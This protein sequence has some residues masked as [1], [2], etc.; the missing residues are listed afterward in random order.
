[1][2][3]AREIASE[4]CADGIE[5]G[6]YL[7]HPFKQSRPQMQSW[8]AASRALAG[9][10]VGAALSAGMPAFANARASLA[11]AEQAEGELKEMALHVKE[12]ADALRDQADLL[13]EMTEAIRKRAELLE[14]EGGPEFKALIQEARGNADAAKGDAEWAV[15]Q[16]DSRQ[17]DRKPDE[18]WQQP[19]VAALYDADVS[20]ML[21]EI[22]KALSEERL[23]SALEELALLRRQALEQ[24]GLVPML[25]PAEPR[26]GQPLFVSCTAGANPILRFSSG[27]ISF[28][29]ADA[30]EFSAGDPIVVP[31][32]PGYLRVRCE[33]P[34]GHL[35]EVAVTVRPGPAA[36]TFATEASTGLEELTV[37]AGETFDVS[38]D[39]LDAAG[40]LV[41]YDE[42]RGRLSTT[43]QP[44][45]CQIVEN[46]MSIDRVGSWR[47]YCGDGE[48]L[49]HPLQVNVIPAFS[50][51]ISARVVTRQAEQP[52]WFWASALA[53]DRYGN[54][55]DSV[56]PDLRL[57]FEDVSG[58]P[59]GV[60]G[61]VAFADVVGIQT[62]FDPT[63][64]RLFY[65]GDTHVQTIMRADLPWEGGS[66]GGV[67]PPPN[68]PD[69]PAWGIKEF[70]FTPSVRDVER[71]QYYPPIGGQ[72]PDHHRPRPVCAAPAFG[73]ALRVTFAGDDATELVPVSIAYPRGMEVVNPR[74][75]M[76]FDNDHGST[77]IRRVS[78]VPGE[79]E[80]TAELEGPFWNIH[81]QVRPAYGLNRLIANVT[82]TYRGQEYVD[83][84]LC[85][86]SASPATVA[87]HDS[88]D[89]ALRDVMAVRLNGRL[90]FEGDDPRRPDRFDSSV[91]TMLAAR[92]GADETTEDMT[93]QILY[94]AQSE[95]RSVALNR[96]VSRDRPW[97]APAVEV[98]TAPSAHFAELVADRDLSLDD[99]INEEGLEDG[100]LM[101][102]ERLVPEVAAMLRTDPARMDEV[103]RA[104]NIR[105]DMTS[106]KSH[107]RRGTLDR[108]TT[109]NRPS[110]KTALL[111]AP[112]ELTQSSDLFRPHSFV[113]I[114]SASVGSVKGVWGDGDGFLVSL[115]RALDW[116]IGWGVF[117][118]PLL[119]G[120]DYADFVDSFLTEGGLETYER[121][122][123]K[124]QLQATAIKTARLIALKLNDKL[125]TPPTVP[126]CLI[127]DT[128]TRV[129]RRCSESEARSSSPR[130][131]VLA[132]EAADLAPQLVTTEVSF[133]TSSPH[134]DLE[135]VT[136]VLGE[137]RYDRV[138]GL[139]TVFV[140]RSGGEVSGGDVPAQMGISVGTTLVNVV[141]DRATDADLF[142][143]IPI[144]VSLGALL[145][146]VIG[147]R[148]LPTEVVDAVSRCLGTPAPIRLS[149]AQVDTIVRS[150][151]APTVA[152]AAAP[153]LDSL[154]DDFGAP[155]ARLVF[156]GIVVD[157]GF[158]EDM[159]TIL[160][161][162]AGTMLDAV[163]LKVTATASVNVSVGLEDGLGGG[164]ALRY[165]L[166]NG[167]VDDV[168]VGVEGMVS[169]F[170]LASVANGVGDAIEAEFAEPALDLGE[171]LGA[172][173]LPS[174]GFS[175]VAGN[176]AYP[177][178]RRSAVDELAA[179]GWHRWWHQQS[180]TLAGYRDNRI[181]LRAD[182]TMRDS[183]VC[184]CLPLGWR[185]GVAGQTEAVDCPNRLGLPVDADGDALAD[186]M[187]NASEPYECDAFLS[188]DNLG[189]HPV[190]DGE[191]ARQFDIC[192]CGGDRGVA[193][194][195]PVCSP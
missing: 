118:S 158:N 170:G 164:S 33:L 45:E 30:V 169:L 101:A 143:G 53:A 147:D 14:Q 46:R 65:T 181:E 106:M 85:P 24:R 76:K 62:A 114:G 57:T 194:T 188:C 42:A 72:F 120:T 12:L 110:I 95:L 193:A 78:G 126:V 166:I 47:V 184:R 115:A 112:D 37:E 69:F 165:R 89:P 64:P 140:A 56:S 128:D 123:I 1:M 67:C 131:T 40:W 111:V 26:V 186:F 15:L 16:I 99:L 5:H 94:E 6:S 25:W 88:T 157:P 48:L 117:Y 122:L 151:T 161:A 84:V 149:A 105:H 127:R 160:R 81:A 17:L 34:D 121:R 10:V 144:E 152:F 83:Q 138:H 55:V 177:E 80:F 190:V 137:S 167:S 23:R 130:R 9:F 155:E 28:A 102:L 104:L 113:G 4:Y 150:C 124:V 187:I 71:P 141:L 156:P 8:R 66:E 63:I 107:V 39:A 192:G 133:S 148:D 145:A 31:Q 175:V 183:P 185:Y 109:A 172:L 87:S 38:C 19:D 171:T 51:G 61:P 77:L 135:V 43:A 98:T 176:R 36:A 173:P 86:F 179:P 195:I 92:F 132:G 191:A 136:G 142:A 58:A 73:Q 7:A 146:E 79:G 11:A 60:G 70:P 74:L 44:G 116:V 153:F 180:Y 35:G 59:L 162:T 100:A 50:Q 32:R 96:D 189:T 3:N 154:T 178:P 41:P 52:G 174:E 13:A 18:Y 182:G 21:A 134:A 91:E 20:A 82:F 103:N 163:T 93:K 2:I 119:A 97:A 108:W 168:S 139:A 54:G 125:L 22:A 27:T 129:P 68:L 49:Q 75:T 29:P 90:F 159:L